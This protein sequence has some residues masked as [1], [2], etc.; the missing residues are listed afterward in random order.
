[1]MQRRSDA[2]SMSRLILRAE[3]VR[4]INKLATSILSNIKHPW[5]SHHNVSENLNDL[6]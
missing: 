4:E 3:V 1:M 5:I 2:I 6:T